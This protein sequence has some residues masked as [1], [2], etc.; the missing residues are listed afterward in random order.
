MRKLEKWC[1]FT[2]KNK[3]CFLTACGRAQN[4]QNEARNDPFSRLTCHLA[5][6]IIMMLGRRSFLMCCPLK[7]WT[8]MAFSDNGLLYCIFYLFVKSH[9]LPFFGGGA[10]TLTN[11]GKK[12]KRFIYWTE[13]LVKS[14]WYINW[15]TVGH[16]LEKLL[17]FRFYSHIVCMYEYLRTF[18]TNNFRQNIFPCYFVCLLTCTSISR[19][20]SLVFFVWWNEFDCVFIYRLRSALVNG[21]EKIGSVSWIPSVRGLIRTWW[22]STY[23]SETCEKIERWLLKLQGAEIFWRAS[24]GLA[25][26]FS[27]IRNFYRRVSVID[28]FSIIFLLC[29]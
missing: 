5:A 10:F 6:L 4:R 9:S 16:F 26:T 15:V 11:D 18:C 22:S 20:K 28:G 14:N 2:R 3:N 24:R 23:V 25:S 21:S 19:Q 27:R 13:C 29:I 8:S 1:N 7:I 12:E 17:R